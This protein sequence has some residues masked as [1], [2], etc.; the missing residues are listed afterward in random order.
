M[1]AALVTTLDGGTPLAVA[2]QWWSAAQGLVR[3]LTN[4]STVRDWLERQASSGCE[5]EEN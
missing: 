2:G 4:S 1:P 3:D 5:R